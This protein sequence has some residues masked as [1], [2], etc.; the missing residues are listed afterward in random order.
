VLHNIGDAPCILE[1]LSLV[2]W[3]AASFWV[4]PEEAA[5]FEHVELQIG[6]DGTSS[7]LAVYAAS[8]EPGPARCVLEVSHSDVTNGAVNFGSIYV[9]TSIGREVVLRNVGTAPCKVTG[10]STTGGNGSFQ[11]VVAGPMWIWEQQVGSSSPWV[12]P[13]V[14]HLTV[15]VKFVPESKGAADGVLQVTSDDP[16][17]PEQS[18]LLEAYAVPD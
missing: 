14:K 4:A 8:V 11:T 16:V 10:V 12:L 17:H 6:F 2:G 18:V 7:N 9:G 1:E 5:G 13:P 15:Q 3:H